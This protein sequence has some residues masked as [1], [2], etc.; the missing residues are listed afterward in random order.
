VRVAW[1]ANIGGFVGGLLAFTAFDPVPLAATSENAPAADA[2]STDDE[3][4]S[5]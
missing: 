4:P 5:R 3:A 2:Q 1:Q